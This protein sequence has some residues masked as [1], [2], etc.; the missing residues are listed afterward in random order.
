MADKSK[1]IYELKKNLRTLKNIRGSGTEL[2]SLYITPNYPLGEITGK[3]KDEYGQ[4]SNIK[5]KSTRKNVQEALEKILNY[6]KLFRKPPEDG[7]A[8]F[9]GNISKN[10]GRSDVKL[11]SIVPP[12]SL[13]VQYYRCDSSF[14]L[15]PL[16]EM[17]LPKDSYGLVVMDGREATLAILRGKQVRIIRSLNSTAHAKVHKGGQSA[18]RYQRLVEESIERYYKR[19]GGAMDKA[20]LPSRLTG[21]IV[22]GPGPA[23]EDFL[24]LKPFNYQ[25]KIIGVI[26]IGYTNEYGVHELM[27]RASDVI[28]EQESIKEKKLVDE[29]MLE[30]VRDGLVTYGEKEVREALETGKA[31]TLLLSEGLRPR[32]SDKERDILEEFVELAES[33]GIDIEFISPETTGGS[34]F[35]NGFRGIGAFLRYK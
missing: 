29:F 8:V 16:E 31:K 2:I 23:K 33:N 1:L 11:F 27:G 12:E 15:S 17:V 25:T 10:Q 26:D 34:Q 32:Q 5:S 9:C 24:K 20:F 7:I 13:T 3:L 35:L 14:S 28:S 6:L 22:G 18:R 21:V 19:I 30:V 4:A